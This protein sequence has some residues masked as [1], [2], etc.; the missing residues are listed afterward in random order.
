MSRPSMGTYFGDDPSSLPLHRDSHVGINM[1]GLD[2]ITG[3]M[4]GTL[5]SSAYPPSPN[6]LR[7]AQSAHGHGSSSYAKFQHQAVTSPRSLHSHQPGYQQQNANDAGFDR[8]SLDPSQQSAGASYRSDGLARSLSMGHGSQHGG[9]RSSSNAAAA[10]A[11]SAAGMFLSP[12]SGN[13]QAHP[14]SS[15]SP[16][17]ATN[18]AS[19][20]YLSATSP[21]GS[22]HSSFIMSGGSSSTTSPQNA[23]SSG[24]PPGPGPSHPGSLLPAYS[25]SNSRRSSNAMDTSGSSSSYQSTALPRSPNSSHEALMSNKA[26]SPNTSHPHRFSTN[27]GGI[28]QIRS[29]SNESGGANLMDISTA[30]DSRS[31]HQTGLKQRSSNQHLAQQ[32]DTGAAGLGDLSD[33]L[34]YAYQGNSVQLGGTSGGSQFL[35]ASSNR[36]SQQ[37]G[38]PRS[39]GEGAY[40]SASGGGAAGLWPSSIS[41]NHRSSMIL[42]P[43]RGLSNSGMGGSGADRS[44]YNTARNSVM[45]LDSSS[46]APQGLG[47]GSSGSM[48]TASDN[49]RTSSA[50]KR[51]SGVHR[52]SR[53]NDGFRRVRD[54]DDLRPVIDKSTAAATGAAAI[55][56]GKAATAAAIATSRRADPAGGFVSPLKAL[57]AYLHHTYHLVNPAFFYELSFNPRRVLTK[58]SK[59]VQN[60]GRDNE[61]SDYILYVNDWLGTEEGHKYLILDILGQGTFGQVVKC[62]DMTT[63][64]IVAVKVIK[65]KPAYFNQ[66]MMEVTVLEMLNGN[67]DPNDEHHI[68]RLKDTFIH[69]KH[70]CLVLELLS[71][72]LYELIKQNSFQ[73]LSTSLVRVFTAQL[74]DAL[75][76]LNE[77]RLIHCDLKPENIL[78]KTL[79]T[80]SI[81]LVDFGS[82]CHEKQTVYTYIQSRFYRSPEVLLGLPYNSAIDMW[83]LGCIAVEL[84]LGLPL[85]PGTSEYNQI[86]RIVEMLGLPP[87][88]MLENGKQTQEFFSVYTDE[89]GRKSYRLKSLEQYSKEHNVQEQPSKKYFKATTLPDIVKTYPMSR[90]SGKSADMQKEMANRSSF[91]DFVS[92]LLSMNPHERWTPQ[93][94]KLHPFI[95]GEKFTKPFRPPPVDA[96]GAHASN[97]SA[98]SSARSKSS[99]ASKHPY[100]GLLPHSSSAKPSNKAFQDAAAYNQ[101][102]AQQQAYNSAAARQQAQQLM[103]NPYTRDDAAGLQA[104]EAKAAAKAQAAQLAQAQAHA[105]AQQQFDIRHSLPSSTSSYYQGGSNSSGSRQQ[106]GDNR[107]SM[108]PP[109]LAKLGLEQSLGGG[110]G[111][112]SIVNRDDPLREWERRQ[113]GLAPSSASGTGGGSSGKHRQSTANYQ[114][115]DLLQQQAELGG[116]WSGSGWDISG[117]AQQGGGAGGVTSSGSAGGGGGF[118]VVVDGSQDRSGGRGMGLQ[119][120]HDTSMASLS[121]PGIA[122][123]PAA[124]ASSGAAGVGGNNVGAGG[125]ARYQ[126]GLSGAGMGGYGLGGMQSSSSS[127]SANQST[128]PFDIYDSGMASLMPPALTPV[129]IQDRDASHRHSTQ[130]HSSSQQA[131]LQQQQ[132]QQHLAQY[133]HQQQQQQQQQQASRDKRRDG[134]GGSGGLDMLGGFGGL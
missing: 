114:Q 133:Q 87:Q 29:S 125:G 70:L 7:A 78:L 50:S 36:S 94:A 121:S 72:N 112:A 83:S 41:G 123:P 52:S 93:Q 45:Y 22:R 5:P 115:L 117:L 105:Q 47:I 90:K 102:L 88:W 111:V 40:G 34:P 8:Y 96:L 48:T 59:P 31:P 25:N 69:A 58:P 16:S 57:T 21:A 85:F 91:I 110:Q 15:T 1:S 42:D 104:A 65:N 129:R 64:E 38:P 27:L 101:H 92:G 3:A 51:E 6:S 99:D 107:L 17:S 39:S 82:A 122:A 119:N 127:S 73:G 74:L 81:K 128:L 33:S 116:G 35:H 28:P 11:A 43:S 86:C 113:N 106:R 62:Q 23:Y 14:V 67:W 46:L 108:I 95:T 124:Y 24:L 97:A 13:A 2:P 56:D 60:D 37:A 131:Y 20:A 132:Q 80:P 79:Q 26:Y 98:S 54:F 66:S 134:S 49:S 10:A 77:A 126:S 44:G 55:S 61:E 30:R 68:L 130:P 53:R 32:Y 109:Q 76:V 9:S 63:H 75:T 120:P 89:F 84:F 118:S 100:G 71:S 4:S 19:Q 18:Y 12:Q 103:N